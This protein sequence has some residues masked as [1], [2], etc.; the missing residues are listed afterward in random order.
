MDRT[1]DLT[2]NLKLSG[3]KMPNPEWPVDHA[4]V[5]HILLNRAQVLGLMGRNQPA[6]NDLQ[7]ELA[8]S[9]KY[10]D[11]KSQAD[12]L[13]QLSGSY[14]ALGLWSK[15][16]DSAGE[17]L[18]LYRE[19]QDKK[20]EAE[21]LNNIGMTSSIMGD[22]PRALEDYLQALR[23]R[24]EIG[25]QSGRTASLM[26]LGHVYNGFGDYP[27]ALEYFS[28]ALKTQEETGDRR[29]QAY[30]LSNLGLVHYRLGDL[31][32]AQ[33]HYL[34]SLAISGETGERHGQA[35]ALNN[36]GLVYFRQG[37][38]A[39]ALEHYIKS[40]KI[41]EETGNR[42]GQAA[43]LNNIAGIQIERR[44]FAEARACLTRAEGIARE[45][46]GKNLLRKIYLSW[47]E[48]EAA[49]C[50][51]FPGQALPRAAEYAERALA[52]AG[53]LKS[54]AGQA[55]ALLLL[56]RIEK[57]EGKFLEAAAIFG[58]LNQPMEEAKA[59]YYHGR[60]MSAKDNVDRARGMFEKLGAKGWLAKVDS[61]PL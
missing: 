17:A 24:E 9:R 25:D 15:M 27:K 51:E 8:L 30:S 59:W 28:Q 1:G 22:Q 56:A 52:L 53:A 37:E 14:T 32:P 19:L 60:V 12:G 39:L 10:R 61:G 13:I 29:G 11:K 49:G 45:G 41:F 16:R 43:N 44:E 31:I 34:R 48:L 54:R 21:C 42:Q 46:G 26:N 2:G 38:L 18:D 47:G 33:E 4:R 57:S 7:R 55:E 23:I 5:I 50:P 35:Q 20:G 3:F 40:L 36:L 6:I 58:E